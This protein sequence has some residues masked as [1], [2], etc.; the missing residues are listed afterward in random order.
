MLVRARSRARVCVC[1][2]VRVC[3]CALGGEGAQVACDAK[4]AD[5]HTGSDRVAPHAS[6]LNNRTQKS[7]GAESST[8][9][10][11][12][13]HLRYSELQHSVIHCSKV[14]T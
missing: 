12:W 13:F 11:Y 2:C 14:A 5:L 6:P 8:L 10:Y 7:S 1:A 9:E 4:I 3:V